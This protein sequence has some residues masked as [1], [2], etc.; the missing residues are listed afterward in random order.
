MRRLLSLAL[1]IGLSCVSYTSAFAAIESASEHPNPSTAAAAWTPILISPVGPPRVFQGGDHKY[2]LVYD[3]ALN[4]FSTHAV[5]I[6]QFDFLDGDNPQRVILSLKGPS[7]AA[8]FRHP[9][10]KGNDLPPI[11]N[12]IVWAN[13]SFDKPEQV[14][15]K[16]IH[17]IVLETPFGDENKVNTFDYTAAPLTVDRTENIVISRPLKGKWMAGG[18]YA[19]M[20]G[21]RTALFPLNNHLVAAQTFAIDWMMVDEKNRTNTGGLS[22]SE[23]YISYGK[24]VLAVADGTVAGVIDRFPDQKPNEPKGDARYHFPAGN[25]I[26]LDLGHGYYAMYAH[27]KPGSIK[28]KEG[29]VVKRGQEIALVGNAGN[30]STPHLHLDI[31]TGPAI[32]DAPGVPYLFDH[33]EVVGAIDSDED[34]WVKNDLAGAPQIVHPSPYNGKHINDLPKDYMIVDFG[35]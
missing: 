11:T 8:V 24:P 19:S 26:V 6:K 9:G 20:T 21:H 15:N 18:G 22:K 27:L 30:S 7:L 14:P 1:G 34:K 13:L 35:D 4:N 33:Y 2:N 3:I 29:D 25:S 28:V 10:G 32:L 17:R 23:T 5:E 31:T 16:L 12:G